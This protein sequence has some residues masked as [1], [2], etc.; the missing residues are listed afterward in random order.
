[1]IIQ[2]SMWSEKPFI[3]DN[4]HNSQ[5]K[6][7]PEVTNVERVELRNFPGPDLLL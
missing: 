6:A 3:I 7:I 5:G 2:I 4:Y 1:M